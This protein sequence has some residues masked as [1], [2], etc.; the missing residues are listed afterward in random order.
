MRF[1]F[2]KFVVDG[3]NQGFTAQQQEPGYLE[4]GREG[5]WVT[6]PEHLPNLFGAYHAAGFTAHAH[7]NGDAATEL[8]LNT[9]ENALEEHPRWNHRHTVTH[10]QLSTAAQYRRMAALGMCANIFSNHIWY[11]GDIHYERVFGP[12]RACRMNAAA[13]ALRHGVSISLHSD[14]PITPMDPLATASYAATRETQSGRILGEQ[15][16]LSVAEALHAI[17]IGGAYQLKMDQ[18]VGSIEAGKFADFAILGS[19]PLEATPA[20]LRDV[21]VYGTVSGGRH[22]PARGV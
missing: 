7:C 14:T 18:D 2:V 8:Y 1:G 5:M 9:V 22:F 20:G 13:T 17:T 15:E 6:P 21:K 19:D 3:S 12:D 11:Y 16:R 10:S 4:F